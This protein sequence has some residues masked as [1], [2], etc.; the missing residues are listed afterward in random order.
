MIQFILGSDEFLGHLDCS[1]AAIVAVSGGTLKEKLKSGGRTFRSIGGEIWIHAE[2]ISANKQIV[3]MQ[4]SANGLDKKDFLGKSDPYIIIS[5]SNQDGTYSAVHKTEVIKNTL[6]P[7]WRP[8]QIRVQALCNGD[9]K[10]LLKFDIFD[11]DEDSQDDLIGSFTTT[12]DRL[13]KGQGQNNIYDC[14]NPKKQQKKKNYKNS[15]TVRLNSISIT[16]E[17]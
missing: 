15:G 9:Y 1:L 17:V 2:E 13:T 10:R 11:W 8:F 16:Q 4:F 6:K 5:R 3:M 12:L 14:I 7:E